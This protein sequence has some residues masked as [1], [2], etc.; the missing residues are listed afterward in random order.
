MASNKKNHF[1][2]IQEVSDV[3]DQ[4]VA[5]VF[6]LFKGQMVIMVHTGSRGFG[7]QICNDYTDILWK[8]ARKYGV[9]VPVK[10]LACA[11]VDS[12]EGRNYFAAMACAVNFAFSNR[13]IITADIRKAC[14]EVLGCKVMP[15]LY[16][17]AHNI[18]KFESYNH[19]KVLVHRKGATRALAPGHRGNPQVYIKTGHPV[20]IPGSMG[21]PSY[22]LTGTELTRE[23]FYSVN[24]GAGR[25]MSRTA[26][27]KEISA[28]EFEQKMGNVLYNTRNP[29]EILD[30]APQAYKDI[31]DV[32]NTLVEIGF[33]KKVARMRPLAVIKGKD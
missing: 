27:Y 7:H 6:G 32:V 12:P 8:A 13:Q 30:E 18:A 4:K 26:A 29:R 23:T 22:V 10:G 21:T 20:L 14:Q 2:E 9:N 33:T 24:H 25:V 28:Q 16:D 31:D 11:P 1:I 3:Y 19:R 15:V 17:V 5:G